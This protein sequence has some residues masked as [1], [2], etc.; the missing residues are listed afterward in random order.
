MSILNTLIGFITGRGL[1]PGIVEEEENPLALALFGAAEEV[2]EKKKGGGEEEDA[3]KPEDDPPVDDDADSRRETSLH[4]VIAEA[5][6]EE[7]EGEKDPKGGGESKKKDDDPD[8]DPKGED[9]DKEKADP[10]PVDPIIDELDVGDSLAP[11]AADTGTGDDEEEEE[12][13]D[14]I[15][16][17][18]VDVEA[19]RLSLARYAEKKFP[20]R[21]KGFGA[22]TLDFL[23]KHKSKV[24]ELVAKHEDDPDYVLAEDKAY[25]R[26]LQDNDPALPAAE[27]KRLEKEQIKDEVRADLAKEQDKKL[28]PLREEDFRRKQ[29]P[30]AN[31][32]LKAFSDTLSKT[33][34][35]DM[36]KVYEKDGPDA[37]ARAFPIEYEV[38]AGLTRQ[39]QA[40][41]ATYIRIVNGLE[42]Y[43]SANP[44]HQA[45]F[46]FIAREG[47]LFEKKGGDKVKNTDGQ[48]FVTRSKFYKMTDEEK[49][50]HWT[51][52]NEH[53][54]GLFRVTTQQAI[55]KQVDHYTKLAEKAGYVKKQ[56]DGKA[57]EQ[58]EE[59]VSSAGSPSAGAAVDSAPDTGG[60]DS[61]LGRFLF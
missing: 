37:A 17:D 30:A 27:T 28:E 12:E 9:P 44:T 16:A 39:A 8:T 5:E 61:P 38:A 45:L 53:V 19:E 47:E 52:S 24:E 33:L 6:E 48:T 20:D 22:K 54:L 13:E 31:K 46:Q 23:K 11:T 49:K 15:E 58:E 51:F 25:Q 4:E 1:R 60:D 21:Y 42:R 2:P 50:E 26:F 34:P 18:L 7:N 29:V 43:D 59:A 40:S 14:P 35:E 56:P 10:D 32:Q 41:A 57:H 3:V 55:A 36:R